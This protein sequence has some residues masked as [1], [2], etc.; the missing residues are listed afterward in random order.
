MTPAMTYKPHSKLP[1]F[2]LGTDPSNHLY[3]VPKNV[4]ITLDI[5]ELSR[6]LLGDKKIRVHSVLAANKYTKISSDAQVI[7]C[8]NA[9]T[10]MTPDCKSVPPKNDTV[11]CPSTIFGVEDVMDRM[12]VVE[13][14]DA[15]KARMQAA[16]APTGFWLLDLGDKLG[17][18]R[19][20]AV[21]VGFDP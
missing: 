2:T 16:T 4:G 17:D 1:F 5:A 10:V 8:P 21:E 6:S 20:V 19:Y 14:L 7:Q 12:C 11:P 13:T 18:K 15:A 9:V 3:V